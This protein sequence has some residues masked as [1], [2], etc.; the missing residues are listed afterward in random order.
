MAAKVSTFIYCLGTDRP[1]VP[2]APINANGILN[3]LVP[4]F[5][6][7]TFTFSI[8]VGIVGMEDK[9]PYL[10]DIVFYDCHDKPLV[11][12]KGIKVSLPDTDAN[13]LGLPDG[14]KGLMLSM[15]FKNVIIRDEGMYSTSVSLNGQKLGDYDIYVKGKNR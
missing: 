4:E 7:S 9:I 11:E 12:A 2:N 15:D 6:P 3:I 8:V 14:A 10:L 13:I 1:N 5:I